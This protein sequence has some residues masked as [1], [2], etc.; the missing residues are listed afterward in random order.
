MED[1][2]E[3]KIERGEEPREREREQGKIRDLVCDGLQ[4]QVIAPAAV[5]PHFLAI[6]FKIF[7]NE[8]GVHLVVSVQLPNGHFANDSFFT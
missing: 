3:E 4:C 2:R 6:S 7:R 5:L 8:L 1:D